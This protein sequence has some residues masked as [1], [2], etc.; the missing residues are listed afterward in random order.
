MIV[1]YVGQDIENGIVRFTADWCVPCKRYAP[2]FESVGRNAAVDFF[3][4][5]V[6]RSP[7]VAANH[8]VR[9]VP[10][11]FVVRNGVWER[12]DQVPGVAELHDAVE[13]LTA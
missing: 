1:D 13:S 12:F 6:E 11:V 3:V 4:I 10:T 5:D 7:G 9:S 8:G 2:T